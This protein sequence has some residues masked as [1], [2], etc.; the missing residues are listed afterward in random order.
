MKA[1]VSEN[2][3]GANNEQLGWQSVSGVAAK[4]RIGN[5]LMAA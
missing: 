2:G 1:Y 5:Q 4:W 3:G